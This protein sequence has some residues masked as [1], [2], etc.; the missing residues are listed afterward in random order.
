MS[1]GFDY[2]VLMLALFELIKNEAFYK[3]GG[4]QRERDPEL[5]FSQCDSTKTVASSVSH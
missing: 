4:I 2:N 1:P 5:N 3:K